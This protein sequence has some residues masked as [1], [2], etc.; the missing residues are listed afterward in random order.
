MDKFFAGEQGIHFNGELVLKWLPGLVSTEQA[1]D[2]ARLM[3]KSVNK[4]NEER[5]DEE[6]IQKS[7]AKFKA[8]VAKAI[9]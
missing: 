2:I 3:A 8:D 4:V 5:K 1:H 9:G 7:M 6:Y